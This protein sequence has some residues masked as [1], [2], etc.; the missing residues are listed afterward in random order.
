ML[1]TGFRAIGKIRDRTE[2][3][4]SELNFFL[5]FPERAELNFWKVG[6]SLITTL[7]G[8]T[9]GIR[10]F[11]PIATGAE[12]CITVGLHIMPHLLHV[13][14]IVDF[15]QNLAVDFTHC[16]PLSICATDWACMD[17]KIHNMTTIWGRFFMQ[18]VNGVCTVLCCRIL[19]LIPQQIC[20]VWICPYSSTPDTDLA[21]VFKASH[22]EQ[23][24]DWAARV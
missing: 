24:Y 16:I 11:F 21:G 20:D 4:R 23:F 2:V 3:I 9:A 19:M 7:R 8:W 13:D 14:F 10:V 6:F 1:Y 15:V 12:L 5:K 17:L 18:W 22:D